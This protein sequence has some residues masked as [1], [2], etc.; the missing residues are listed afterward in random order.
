MEAGIVGLPNVGKSTLYNALTNGGAEAQ[1]FPFCTIEPNT[2]IVVVPDPRLDTLSHFIKSER[3]LP[4]TMKIVDI[5]GIVRGASEG[6]GL[7]NKFLTHIREVDAILHVVRCFQD[8]DVTHVDGSVDPLRDIATIETELMLADLQTVESAHSKAQKLAKGKDADAQAAV[9][10]LEKSIAALQA[11]NPVR[12]VIEE[13]ADLAPVLKGYG[14]ITAKRVLFVANVD[15]DSLVDDNEYVTQVKEYAAENGGEV[16]NAR[17]LQGAL[18]DCCRIATN[19]C[20][21]GP[22]TLTHIYVSTS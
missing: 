13:D 3:I 14:L 2:G 12:S 7:G 18:L 10:A 6:E 22:A 16:V 8:E 20:V 21:P 1:N 15:E 5:A 4:A 19:E 9:A 11:G 17:A